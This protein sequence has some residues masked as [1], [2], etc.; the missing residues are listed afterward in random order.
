MWWLDVRC[1]MSTSYTH[2]IKLNK[3]NYSWFYFVVFFF[4]LFFV[5]FFIRCCW[6]LCSWRRCFNNSKKDFFFPYSFRG[7]QASIFLSLYIIFYVPLFR[8]LLLI[9]EFKWNTNAFVYAFV[10]SQPNVTLL[11]NAKPNHTKNNVYRYKYDYYY[12]CCCM[13][14]LLLCMITSIVLYKHLIAIC[15]LCMF[16][17]YGS[18]IQIRCSSLNVVGV[19]LRWSWKITSCNFIYLDSNDYNFWQWFW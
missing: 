10:W 8:L 19:C 18:I 13:L 9:C 6:C 11:R 17:I 2:K 3:K 12:C 15:V 5:C 14:L 4:L 16:S 1:T 7:V